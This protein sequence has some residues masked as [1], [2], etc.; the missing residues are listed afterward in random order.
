M[1]FSNV[2]TSSIYFTHV[3]TRCL[4]TKEELSIWQAANQL[5]VA[6]GLVGDELYLVC[7]RPPPCRSLIVWK[8]CPDSGFLCLQRKIR[9]PVQ[10]RLVMGYFPLKWPGMIEG[11]GGGGRVPGK[12][13]PPVLVTVVPLDRDWA[14]WEMRKI[15]L[16]TGTL[17]WKLLLPTV[18]D[19]EVLHGKYSKNNLRQKMAN[20]AYL[21]LAKK[22]YV[23]ECSL[24]LSH[25]VQ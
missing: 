6:V 24:F 13:R 15:D 23:F 12:D 20:F 4:R 18:G 5:I 21:S 22:L 10:F 2:I 9:F 3:K 14:I 7:Q 19:K 1:D 11:V 17:L 25:P 16:E 8:S